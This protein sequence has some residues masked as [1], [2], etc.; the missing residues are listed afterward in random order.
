[1]DVLNLQRNPSMLPHSVVQN[2]QRIDSLLDKMDAKMHDA[3]FW[4]HGIF[5]NHLVLAG[6]GYIEDGVAQILSDY[7]GRNGNSEIARFVQHSTARNLSLNCNKIEKILHQFN[8]DWWPTIKEHTAPA[9][10]SAVDSLKTLRDQIAHGRL[11]G[12]GFI[13]VRNYYIR[14]KSFIDDFSEVILA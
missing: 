3:D 2:R 7:G 9:N 8:K 1:M 5:A 14:S 12:T 13:E 6:A 10:L 4:V 11:N